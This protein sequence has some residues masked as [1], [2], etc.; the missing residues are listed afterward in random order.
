MGSLT[1]YLCA[2]RESSQVDLARF[3]EK[4]LNVTFTLR[5]SD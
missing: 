3:I 5:M 2:S 1:G 4:W